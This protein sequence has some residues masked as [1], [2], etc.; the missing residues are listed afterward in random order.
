VSFL[1]FRHLYLT[2][3]ATIAPLRLMISATIPMIAAAPK[4]GLMISATIPMIAAAPKLDLNNVFARSVVALMPTAT[5]IIPVMREAN[6]RPFAANSNI[7]WTLSVV[8]IHAKRQRAEIPDR[9]HAKVTKAL[10]A[11]SLLHVPV[12]SP[13]IGH[14]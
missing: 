13:S 6:T 10:A 4:L 7:R 5:P 8:T 1:F 14:G 9:I 12:F 2:K 11:E 3:S